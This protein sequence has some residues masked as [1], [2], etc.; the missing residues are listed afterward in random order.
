[1]RL[2]EPKAKSFSQSQLLRLAIMR[3]W[4]TSLERKNGQLQEAYYQS[5]MQ[6]LISE[7]RLKSEPPLTD[8]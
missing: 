2:P 7:E 6:S 4:E 8:M 5:R 3:T 1:M